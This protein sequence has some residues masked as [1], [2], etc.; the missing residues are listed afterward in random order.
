MIVFDLKC[1]LGHVFEAWFGSSEDYEGQKARGLVSCPLCG[2]GEIDKAV[3]APAVPAK[4]N[5]RAQP[6]IAPPAPSAGSTGP[7]QMSGGPDAVRARAMLEALAMAQAEALKT[8]EWVGKD[9]ADVARAIHYGEQEARGIHGQVDAQE[10]R[11]LMEEGVEVAPLLVP[12]VP[13]E[14][15]N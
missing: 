15:K 14:A 4:S 5:Q 2:N 12:F 3:M 6:P 7:V 9:F 10:A 1:A 11:S 13:P 8:S